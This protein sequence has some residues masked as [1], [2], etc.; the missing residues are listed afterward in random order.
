LASRTVNQSGSPSTTTLYV[1]YLAGHVIA[2]T[3]TTGATQRE[4]IWMDDLPVAIVSGVN[5]ST[6]T[7]YYVHADHLGRPA[8]MT[9]QN[10]TWVWGVIYSPFGATS[11]IWLNP[12]TMDLIPSR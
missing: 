6:P 4:Y 10:W 3:D 11:Y 9:A 2:E 12:A 7:L 1:D 8:R 5:T